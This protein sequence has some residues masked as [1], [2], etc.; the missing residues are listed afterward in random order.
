MSTTLYNKNDSQ[1]SVRADDDKSYWIPPKSKIT[2]PSTVKNKTLPSG[3]RV[4]RGLTEPT[5]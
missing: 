1:V 5:E 2:I 3:V 4:V